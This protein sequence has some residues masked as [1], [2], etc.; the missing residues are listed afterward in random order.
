MTD[1]MVT[2]NSISQ[3]GSEMKTVIS[4]FVV[5]LFFTASFIFA[6]DFKIAISEKESYK[7]SVVYG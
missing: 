5:V 1:Y 6:D 3:G 2:C 4:I 7:Y